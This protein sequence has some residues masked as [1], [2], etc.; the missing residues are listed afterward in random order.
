[1]DLDIEWAKKVFTTI[2]M[3][4]GNKHI[5]EYSYAENKDSKNKKFRLNSRFFMTDPLQNIWNFENSLS[6]MGLYEN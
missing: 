4:N 2:D 3:N 5:L 6:L 1:M